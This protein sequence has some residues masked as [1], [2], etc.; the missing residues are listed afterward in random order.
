MKNQFNKDA[1][2]LIGESWELSSVSG[3]VSV[4]SNG[5]LKGESL[6]NLIS[7]YKAEILGQRVYKKYGTEFPLLFKFID[8]AQDLSVQLHPDD[9][10]A[11]A[12]HNS[13][14][15][16]EMWYIMEAE[17]NSRLILGLKENTTKKIFDTAIS[18]NKIPE[19]LSEIP[20]DKGDTFFIAPGT[21]HAIGGGIV[22]AEIQQ[23]SD[24]TYR[25]Y[26][27]DRPGLD[28]EMRQLHTEDAKKAI[29]YNVTGA[30]LNPEVELNSPSLLKKC[31]YFETNKLDLNKPITRNLIDKDSFVVYMCV[32][33]KASITVNNISEEIAKGETL[34]IPSSISNIEIATNSATLL[35]VYIP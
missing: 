35:E 22:L 2:G 30:I 17:K 28:G 19:I 4:V 13:F 8:A 24:I 31:D 18:T 21:T 34:L 33:G 20:V 5:S 11:K 12:R 10:L 26:D 32:E 1:E 16:T 23:T 6:N 29:N 14:G 27:W 15:K 9:A 3:N 7:N 25:I